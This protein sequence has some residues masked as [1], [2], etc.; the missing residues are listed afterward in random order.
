MTKLAEAMGQ[1]G[2]AGVS[3]RGHGGSEATLRGSL[4]DKGPG[5]GLAG[6]KSVEQETGGTSGR[7]VAAG[8]RVK[9][10]GRQQAP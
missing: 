1:Q 5:G 10:S 3:S 2:P 9:G 8:A 6:R 7:S 4:D